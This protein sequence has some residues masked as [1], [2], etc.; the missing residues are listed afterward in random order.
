MKNK[1]KLYYIVTW[2]KDCWDS[3]IQHQIDISKCYKLKKGF[4]NTYDYREDSNHMYY[5]YASQTQLC[6]K[7]NN[8]KDIFTDFEK[9]KKYAYQKITEM[10]LSRCKHLIQE[11][12]EAIKKISGNR[13]G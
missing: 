11:R 12:D 5:N 6:F 10:Y 8:K 7:W 13:E 9:A 4:I 1:L 2:N 3:F